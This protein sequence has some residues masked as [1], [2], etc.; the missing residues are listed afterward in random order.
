MHLY[1]SA[2]RGAWTGR[3][4]QV[5]KAGPAGYLARLVLGPF[6]MSTSKPR[7]PLLRPPIH[8]LLSFV[9]AHHECPVPLLHHGVPS[10]LSYV[11]AGPSAPPD[12]LR[13]VGP[14][15]QLLPALPSLLEPGA[16]QRRP[17]LAALRD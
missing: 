7:Q 3:H 13:P 16:W 12:T 10:F 2:D 9:R 11:Q 1:K 15:R 5:H 14:P 6:L 8:H 17:G 4:A